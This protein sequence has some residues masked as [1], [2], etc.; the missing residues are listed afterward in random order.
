M[1]IDR[2]NQ[3]WSTDITYMPLPNRLMELTAVI[4]LS[5]T[6]DVEF[7]VEALEVALSQGKPDPILPVRQPPASASVAEEPNSGRSLRQEKKVVDR[8]T[9]SAL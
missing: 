3:V 2:V 7:S 5:N 4:E 9:P 8:A 1:A 6:R